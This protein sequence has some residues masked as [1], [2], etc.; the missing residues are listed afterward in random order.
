M[1]AHFYLSENDNQETVEI[2]QAHITGSHDGTYSIVLAP[3]WGGASLEG[4]PMSSV[5]PSLEL[6]QLERH[7]RLAVMHL[8]LA[9]ACRETVLAQMARAQSTVEEVTGM[10]LAG[11]I[12]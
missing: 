10:L 2:K 3:E 9:A 5:L 8:T 11:D 7:R 6:A 1:F 4:V 12:I